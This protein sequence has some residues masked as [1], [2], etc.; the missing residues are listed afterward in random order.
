MSKIMGLIVLIQ[1]IS[2]Q[3]ISFILLLFLLLHWYVSRLE[4]CWITRAMVLLLNLEHH[5]RKLNHNQILRKNY[6]LKKYNGDN[7]C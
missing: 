4:D 7:N 6:L 3:E 5:I 2:I 1:I